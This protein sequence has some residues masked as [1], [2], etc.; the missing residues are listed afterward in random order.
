MIAI[1]NFIPQ[2]TSK[3]AH[4]PTEPAPTISFNF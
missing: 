4:N 2:T 1:L 3:F